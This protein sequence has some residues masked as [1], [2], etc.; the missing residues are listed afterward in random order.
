[1]TPEIL[2]YIYAVWG[3]RVA[4]I[5]L[6]IFFTAC[7]ASE[8]PRL[9]GGVRAVEVDMD[10]AGWCFGYRKEE[11]IKYCDFL[12]KMTMGEHKGST[13]LWGMRQTLQTQEVESSLPT[14]LI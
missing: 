1:M 2:K 3:L 13:T 12:I 5:I 11:N 9:L 6:G 8:C 14:K 7:A 4:I 10:S